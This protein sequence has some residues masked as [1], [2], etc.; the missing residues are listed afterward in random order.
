[1]V[2]VS[3]HIW[4]QPPNVFT[5]SPASDFG[6]TPEQKK[7]AA[8]FF[9]KTLPEAE[10]VALT[11]EQASADEAVAELKERLEKAEEARAA[12]GGQ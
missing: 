7:I 12:L 8:L 6:N 3:A 9:G 1:M 10:A 5:E 11:M 4:R 2:T